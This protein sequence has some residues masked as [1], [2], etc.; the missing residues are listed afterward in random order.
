[1]NLTHILSIYIFKTFIEQV[2]YVR[3]RQVL[4]LISFF[5]TL[6]L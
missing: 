2:Q 5:I 4:R 1:M 3:N 6:N